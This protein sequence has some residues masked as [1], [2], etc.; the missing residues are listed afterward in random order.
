MEQFREIL[1]A[2]PDPI[3]VVDTAGIVRYANRQVESAFGYAP[4]DIEGESVETLLHA[5]DRDS[6][7][8]MREAYM[9]DP[10]PRPMGSGPELSVLDADGTEIPVTISLGP[11]ERA[12]ETLV[13]ATVIDVTEERARKIEFHRRTRTLAAL[14]RATQELLKTTDRDLG[15]EAAVA[16]VED[17]LGLPL[18][19]IWLHEEEDDSLRPAAWTDTAEEVVGDHPVFGPESK[20]LVRKAFEDGEVMYVPNVHDEPE[21]HNPETSIRSEFIVPLGRYGVLV[22]GSR[23][24]DAFGEADRTVARLWGATVTMVFVRVERER[25]L[26]AREAQI[27]RERD[28]LEEFASVVSHDLRSPLNVAA[29]NLELALSEFDSEELRT[30]DRALS[31]MMDIIEDVLTLAR[32]GE[33][34]D[35]VEPVPLAA[36]AERCWVNVDTDGGTLVVTTDVSVVADRSRLAQVLENLF[37]NAIEHGTRE[38][39]DG[40]EVEIGALPGGDGFYVADD[41]PGIAPEVREDAFEAGV[42]TNSNGTGFG[43]RIVSEIARAH[44][45]SVSIADAE[46][47]GARF[48]FRDVDVVEG[49]RN[50]E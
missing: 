25:Q 31:R 8:L 50:G 32:Q 23:D 6:H 19:A 11:V 20:G 46:N 40:T 21:R 30:V 22:I 12:G 28:R 2:L 36:F 34:V 33:D 14:H 49:A 7:A 43:L 24:P 47:G 39:G 17:V 9:E 38:G 27:A 18:A 1:E 4:S 48:E 29:G 44:G 13:L 26:R 3:F 16:Y 15:A 41:G 37:R 5:E 35:E 10:K 42:T 45:W